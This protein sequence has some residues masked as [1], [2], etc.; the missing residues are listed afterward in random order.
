MVRQVFANLIFDFSI[1]YFNIPAFLWYLY[2]DI[3]SSWGM[4]AKDDTDS[5]AAN[6][7]NLQLLVGIFSLV[8]YRFGELFVY[9]PWAMFD[10]FCIEKAYGMSRATCGSF[11]INRAAML[12]EY[13]LL[14]LPIFMLIVKVQ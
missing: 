11:L 13:C 2:T 14:V 4:C 12:I 3:V 10:T 9:T 8:T 5:G 7:Y 6:S 1:I